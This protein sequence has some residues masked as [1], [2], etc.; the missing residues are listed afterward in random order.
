MKNKIFFEKTLDIIT[1]FYKILSAVHELCMAL[2][3]IAV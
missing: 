3:I 2:A 1:Q